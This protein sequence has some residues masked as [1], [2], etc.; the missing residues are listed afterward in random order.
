MKL[1]LVTVG[2]TVNGQFGFGECLLRT[3]RLPY[4]LLAAVKGEVLRQLAETLTTPA[5]IQVWIAS[6]TPF[7][8]EP[9]EDET[10]QMPDIKVNYDRRN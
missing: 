6:V 8:P 5:E 7:D 1:F 9:G 2:Y 4:S 10:P 3:E